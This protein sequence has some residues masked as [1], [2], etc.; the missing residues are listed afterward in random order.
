MKNFISVLTAQGIGASK[1]TAAGA[2][3]AGLHEFAHVVDI[4]KVVLKT[5]NA[6]TLA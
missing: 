1:E 3:Q 2:A 6:V 4:A 5:I